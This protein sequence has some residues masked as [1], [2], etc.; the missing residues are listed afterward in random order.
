MAGHYIEVSPRDVIWENL[1]MNPYEAFVRRLVS[2]AIT[3]G[4]ILLWSLPGEINSFLM[5]WFD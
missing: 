1:N 5:S 4:I 2:Y 3:G